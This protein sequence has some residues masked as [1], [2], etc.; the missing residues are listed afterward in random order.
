MKNPE[1]LVGD[2]DISPELT[3]IQKLKKFEAVTASFDTEVSH[4]F[5]E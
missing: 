5:L 4:H 2:L 3:P 1:A